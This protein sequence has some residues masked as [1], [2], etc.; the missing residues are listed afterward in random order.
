MINKI[1]KYIV[2]LLMAAI[3]IMAILAIYHEGIF[4]TLFV[5]LILLLL[6]VSLGGPI[7]NLFNQ[8]ESSE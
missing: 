7:F 1:M 5:S 2:I 8:L 4:V 6:C 3:S